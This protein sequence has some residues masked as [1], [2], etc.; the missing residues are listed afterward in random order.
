ML[1]IIHSFVSDESNATGRVN[2]PLLEISS[3]VPVA[4]ILVFRAMGFGLEGVGGVRSGGMYARPSGVYP[5]LRPALFTLRILPERAG[6]F[7]ILPG[8]DKRLFLGA[9]WP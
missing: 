9:V 3:T 6:L 7:R 5:P 1:F 4:Q 8:D 2:A